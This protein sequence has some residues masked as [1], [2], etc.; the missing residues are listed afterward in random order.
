M[1]VQIVQMVRAIALTDRLL[2]ALDFDGTVAPFADDPIA[3]RALPAI[4]ETVD[5]LS[6]LD[7]TYVA[8]VSGRSVRELAIV[9]ERPEM[10][11]ILLSGSH[12]AEFLLPAVLA[13][14][15]VPSGE[16]DDRDGV[17][18]GVQAAVAGLVGIRIEVKACGFALHTRT[19]RSP[20]DI[21][22]ARHAVDA[23]MS[24]HPQWRRRT[25]H[26]VLE[27]SWSVVGKDDAIRLLREVTCAS[28]VLF[29][30]DDTTDEDALGDLESGD[31]G[32]HVGSGNTAAGLTVSDPDEL[33]VV[34][35]VIASMRA[36]RSQ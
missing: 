11:P 22:I 6:R 25:G 30:G 7:E 33:A 9:T 29:A 10:S 3:V 18:A 21:G 12:G 15:P 28:A 2:V 17:I 35:R 8:Y 32:I 34:L 16:P 19:A 13:E 36:G 4:A 31:L 5:V 20:A 1:T 23:I 14:A 24:S 27:Y 26:D